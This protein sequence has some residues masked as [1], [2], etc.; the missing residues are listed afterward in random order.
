MA[1]IEFTPGELKAYFTDK[2][3]HYFCKESRDKEKDMRVHADGK[4]PEELINERRPNESA[5]VLAYRKKIFV[6][7]TKPFFNK[8]ENT[9]QKDGCLRRE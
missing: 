6:P 1:K 5:E 8:I 3:N 9:L 4:F 2:R 7:T